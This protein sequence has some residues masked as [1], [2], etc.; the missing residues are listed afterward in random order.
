[1]KPIGFVHVNPGT[2]YVSGGTDHY[3]TADE[4]REQAQPSEVICALVPVADLDALTAEVE[5]LRTPDLRIVYG[6]ELGLADAQVE[7]P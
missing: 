6:Y 1:M 7:R 4:A 2:N 5:R 3:D